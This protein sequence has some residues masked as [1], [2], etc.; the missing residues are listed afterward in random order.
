LWQRIFAPLRLDD[1]TFPTVDPRLRG[2]HARG[3]LRGS[4]DSPYTECTTLS[5]SESWTAGAIVATPLDVAAF[6][7]ALFEG[8]VLDPAGLARMTDCTEPLDERCS[9][10]LGLV[11]YDFGDG[12]VAF[13]HHG[14]V[15]GFTTMALR[16]TTGRCVVLYQNG[17][18]VHDV[19]TS[20]TPF[21]AATVTA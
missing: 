4:A 8:A 6:F 17:I 7:A 21:V 10:G 12:H 13:G 3:H 14:G 20:R 11:R 1:T 2:A 9:R 19:L 5:P 16:T 15:P 18:D